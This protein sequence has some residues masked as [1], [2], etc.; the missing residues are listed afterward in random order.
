MA[1]LERSR[2]AHTR[3]PDRARDAERAGREDDP[4]YWAAVA[5]SRAV[6]L[7]YADAVGA[8]DPDAAL[9]LRAVLTAE[10]SLLAEGDESARAEGLAAPERR[11][12][13]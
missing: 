12:A 3:S 10:S 11:S 4:S 2:G 5:E 6:T 1:R 7:A 8:Q 9:A 13:S